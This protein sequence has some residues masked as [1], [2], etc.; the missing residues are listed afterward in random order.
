MVD[1]WNDLTAIMN[2]GLVPGEQKPN[3]HL[4]DVG[5][6]R[7]P[8]ELYLNGIHR[9]KSPDVAK[10]ADAFVRHR[11]PRPARSCIEF[12][13]KVG[14]LGLVNQGQQMLQPVAS[15]G[16]KRFSVLAARQSL[17]G[18]DQPLRQVARRKRADIAQAANV[19]NAVNLRAESSLD[20]Q[21]AKRKDE[22]AQFTD[23][24]VANLQDHN[25]ELITAL[26]EYM[27]HQSRSAHRPTLQALHAAR[28]GTAAGQGAASTSVCRA[29]FG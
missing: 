17:R 29:T 23:V 11:V 13:G 19:E 7:N 27:V 18:I 4:E 5:R 9:I 8:G 21:V 3:L 12:R 2:K 6:N 10:T 26:K 20:S 1:R 25:E 15:L 14:A 28:Q 16:F 22:F 24:V